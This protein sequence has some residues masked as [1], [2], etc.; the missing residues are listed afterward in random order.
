MS[1]YLFSFTVNEEEVSDGD[2]GCDRAALIFKC[3]IEKAPQ[4]CKRYLQVIFVHYLFL[5]MTLTFFAVR[6]HHVIEVGR[7]TVKMTEMR[8]L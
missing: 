1:L 7:K 4:V 6:F 8:R 5:Y 2:K 3:S